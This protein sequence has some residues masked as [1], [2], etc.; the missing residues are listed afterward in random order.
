M[1]FI[2][3]Y[4]IITFIAIVLFGFGT[5]LAEPHIREQKKREEIHQQELKIYQAYRHQRVAGIPDYGYWA[6]ASNDGSYIQ[7][8]TQ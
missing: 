1:I 7:T 6:P 4:S 2:I 3:I 8:D 5:I